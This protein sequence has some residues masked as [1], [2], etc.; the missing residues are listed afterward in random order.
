MK[1]TPIL[2]VMG[3]I[4]AHSLRIHMMASYLHYPVTNRCT[5]AFIFDE[6]QNSNF[7][8]KINESI[9]TTSQDFFSISLLTTWSSGQELG[10]SPR[11]SGFDSPWLQLFQPFFFFKIFFCALRINHIVPFDATSQDLQKEFEYYSYFP[12]F[13]LNLIQNVCAPICDQI[14]DI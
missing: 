7:P 3:K 6:I 2:K 1:S 11:R 4:D 5:K 8:P 12:S 9:S 10:F 14:M 13:L